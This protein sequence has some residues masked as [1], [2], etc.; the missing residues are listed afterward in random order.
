[1]FNKIFL[2]SL[3]L[4]LTYWFWLSSDFTE[5]S[6]WIA[7]F[8]F[9]MMLLKKWFLSYSWGVLEKILQ[10]STDKTYKSLLFGFFASSIM[11]SSS[12]VTIITISFLSAELIW[13]IQWI[14]IIFWSSVWT[15]TTAW[16]IAWIWMKINIWAYAMPMIVF[17][18]IFNFQKNKNIN[19]FG[20]ILAGL[21]FIFLWIHFMKTWFESFQSMVSLKDYAIPWFLWLITFVSLG[22]IATILMQSSSATIAL[23]ITALFLWEVNYENALGLVIWANIGTTITWIIW[24]LAG[25]I[26]WKRLAFADFT[27]KFTT[28]IIFILFISKIK[29]FVFYLWDFIWL[30]EDDYAL[31]LALFHTLFNLSWVI[32]LVWFIPKISHLSTII[33]KEKKDKNII[34]S[35]YLTEN[36]LDFPETAL[37]SLLKESKRMYDIVKELIIN[38]FSLKYEDIKENYDFDLLKKKIKILPIEE[39]EK[40]YS[41]RVKNLYWEIIDYSIK[42]ESNNF[43]DH[44]NSFNHIQNANRRFIWTIKNLK[45]LLENTSKYIKSTNLEIKNQYE[46]IIKDIIDTII[47][48]DKIENIEENEEKLKLLYNMELSIKEKNILNNW[49][50]NPLIKNNKISNQMATSLI[51]DSYFKNKILKDLFKSVKVIFNNENEIINNWNE[52][53]NWKV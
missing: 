18:M 46:L 6:A 23:V 17:W 51:N 50:I 16:L 5:I 14:W 49:Q 34:L 30:K 12:L 13:L 43:T 53:I 32:L 2:A 19:W 40:L 8:L 52:N 45:I 7:I 35:K 29:D 31:R 37:N 28:W 47:Q 9:W 1:M 15:T 48:I 24:S 27:F 26:N 20:S 42:A 10:K 11:Q 3:L 36:S 44:Y 41:S 39:L 21:W 4:L 22:I 25:N 38:S 33:L